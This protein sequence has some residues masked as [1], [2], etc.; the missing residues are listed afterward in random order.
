MTKR[1][2]FSIDDST[3][4]L[5]NEERGHIETLKNIESVKNYSFNLN[6]PDEYSEK[7]KETTTFMTYLYGK[8][9]VNP[10]YDMF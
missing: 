6:L 10:E 4:Q 7:Y 9:A 3:Q 1:F 2:C 5:I 8:I